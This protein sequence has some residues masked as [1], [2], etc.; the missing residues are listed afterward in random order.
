MTVKLHL[1]IEFTIFKKGGKMKQ[2]LPYVGAFVVLLALGI[3]TL[4][5]Q[6]LYLRPQ[7]GTQTAYSLST[8][9]KLT[10]SSGNV[11]VTKTSGNPDSYVL[12]TLRYMNFKNLIAGLDNTT[13]N[14][15]SILY[16]NPVVDELNI[17]L[18]SDNHAK[19]SI[20]ILVLC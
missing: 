10:F 13:S 20:E 18:T 17:K 11:V 16:P 3:M 15:I 12:S 14:S 8:I 4:Q 7:S 9:K 19:I 5:A 2:K 1:L 6:S